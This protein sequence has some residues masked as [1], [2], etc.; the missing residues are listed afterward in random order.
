MAADRDH[1]RRG[2]TH[3][4]NHIA[5]GVG[6]NVPLGPLDLV[7]VVIAKKAGRFRGFHALAVSIMPAL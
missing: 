7:T 2:M 5:L 6:H 3:G 4:M 1:A